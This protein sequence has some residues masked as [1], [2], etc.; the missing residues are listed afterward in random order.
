MNETAT[1]VP[2]DKVASDSGA[3]RL[4]ILCLARDFPNGEFPRLGLWTERLVRSCVDACETMVVSPVP[5]FPNFPGLPAYSR[6]RRV[7]HHEVRDG[8][9][10]FH[11]RFLAGPGHSLRV[12][13]AVA[14][15]AA[16][17]R[18]VARVHREFPFDLI[19]AHFSFPDGAVAARLGRRYKVPVV[20]TEHASWRPWMD[21]APMVRRQAIAA[22][23]ASTFVVAVSRALR[24]SIESFTGDPG[25]LRVIPNIVDGTVFTLRSPDDVVP[26]DR[27]LFVGTMRLVKG[28]DILLEAVSI[29]ANRDRDV[30]LAVVGDG[31]YR[32]YNRDQQF[33]EQLMKKLDLGDRVEFIGPRPPEGVAAEIRKSAAVVVSSRRETFGVV[34]A[35]SLSSGVPV[36]ATRCGGTED[37][38]I[39][40]VGELVDNEDPVALAEGIERVLDSRAG[41]DPAA[42]RAYALE[43]FGMETVGARLTALYREALD[44]YQA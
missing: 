21:R 24:D 16:I 13:E 1:P 17:S 12:T 35:E 39:P 42:L 29:L 11:P 5:Y 41:Y 26:N 36:V 10:V 37:I 9:E 30:R 25:R 18:L 38:V 2:T 7:P 23:R 4:R 3:R 15:H 22:A 34:L 33:F 28:L 20:I 27:L 19:H 6:F 44:V 31:F 32:A 40:G 8:I 14:Y 43:S